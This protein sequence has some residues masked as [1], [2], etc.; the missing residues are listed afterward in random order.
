M[1]TTALLIIDM[2]RAYFNAASLKQCQTQLVEACNRLIR[3]AND[4]GV[5]V[6]MVQ[7]MHNKDIS[8]WSLNMLKDKQGYLFEGSNDVKPMPGLICEGTIKVTKTRDS[9]FFRTALAG[10]LDNYQVARLVLAGVSTHTCIAQ[11]AS[12]AYALNFD[13]TIATDA[14][15]SHQP[16]F[17]QPALD[18]LRLEYRQ[19]LY[20]VKQIT[21]LLNRGR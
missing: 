17:H 9:A 10:M 13:V 18:R 11:T 20:T 16:E 2:Q 5:P 21:S 14:V 1:K 19:K 8:T 3:A 4:N 7:T 12:D 6:F 15:A